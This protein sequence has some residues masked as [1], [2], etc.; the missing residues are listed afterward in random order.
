MPPPLAPPG[1]PA[2]N[3]F[4]APSHT[5]N[6]T[7]PPTMRASRA[8]LN[9][10]H[11]ARAPPPLVY[12]LGI[13]YAAKHSP[14]FVPHNAHPGSQGFAGQASKLGRW[15]DT[16]KALPA[17]RGELEPT[18]DEH[19][20]GRRELDLPVAGNKWGAGEDFFAV[21]STD[22]F[23]SRRVRGGR[24]VEEEARRR[25]GERRRRCAAPG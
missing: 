4:S 2:P 23:V 14:P 3:P 8:V 25:R 17:G 11:P 5:V 22:T 1:D 6:K 24:G 12:N 19:E 13:S 15:V 10:A 16:M 9:L 20:A 21:V 7:H 18:K